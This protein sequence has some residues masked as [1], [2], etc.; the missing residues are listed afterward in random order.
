MSY[1][2]YS[3][4]KSERCSLGASGQQNPQPRR[5]GPLPMRIP[6]RKGTRRRYRIITDSMS[7]VKQAKTVCKDDNDSSLYERNLCLDH[8]RIYE[9]SRGIIIP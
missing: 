5:Q 6:S 1:Y 2:I 4:S 7:F 8:I 9:D 3:F